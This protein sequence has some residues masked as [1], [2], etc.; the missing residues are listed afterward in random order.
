MILALRKQKQMQG[1]KRE[2]MTIIIHNQ[3]YNQ[4]TIVNYNKIYIT[5]Q[6]IIY[7]SKKRIQGKG[8]YKAKR[9]R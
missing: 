2:S 5:K 4:P 3:A 1:R 7:S 8:L 9:K 6:N